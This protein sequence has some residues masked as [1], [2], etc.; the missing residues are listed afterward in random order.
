MRTLITAAS[1]ELSLS[2][3][4]YA[5]LLR[6]FAAEVQVARPV[7]GCITRAGGPE[8]ESGELRTYGAAFDWRC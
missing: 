2:K 5:D 3:K 1:N 8:G 7:Q 4:D 6:S